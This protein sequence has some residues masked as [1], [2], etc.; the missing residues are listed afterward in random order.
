M[1]TYALHCSLTGRY[2]STGLQ[3]KN[4]TDA[5]KRQDLDAYFPSMSWSC[6]LTGKGIYPTDEHVRPGNE[7]A[8]NYDLQDIEKYLKG[9]ALNFNPHN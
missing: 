9:C 1:N 2:L 7:L 6:L 5:L 3:G 4:I 8:R